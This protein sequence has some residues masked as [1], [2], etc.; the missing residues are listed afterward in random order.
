M[1]IRIP[2]EIECLEP[3]T[4]SDIDP[5]HSNIGIATIN[6]LVADLRRHE[7]HLG[8]DRLK[9][10]GSTDNSI[11]L[12]GK[13][14]N[15]LVDALYEIRIILLILIYTENEERKW[16]DPDGSD[17]SGASTIPDISEDHWEWEL[18]IEGIRLV[19]QELLCTCLNLEP[20]LGEELWM[21]LSPSGAEREGFTRQ[22]F[23][24][25][26]EFDEGD[27]PPEQDDLDAESQGEAWDNFQFAPSLCDTETLP[28]NPPWPHFTRLE[29]WKDPQI[30][31]CERSIC[32]GSAHPNRCYKFKYELAGSEGVRYKWTLEAESIED[33]DGIGSGNEPL[34]GDIVEHVHAIWIRPRATIFQQFGGDNIDFPGIDI[35][36]K[37]NGVE[38]WSGTLSDSDLGPD[39][40]AADPTGH[41][42]DP[43]D[44]DPDS[45]NLHG[46]EEVEI[47][48]DPI[49]SVQPGEMNIEGEEEFGRKRFG[50]YYGLVTSG[51]PDNLKGFHGLVTIKIIRP[52]PI[53]EDI[54]GF[55]V[56][57]GEPVLIEP[58]LEAPGVPPI[59]WSLAVFEYDIEEIVITDFIFDTETGILSFTP[60]G[61]GR[62]KIVFRATGANDKFDIEE[63]IIGVI[64]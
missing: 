8:A 16:C 41:G 30:S 58:E 35:T 59:E 56:I 25:E 39:L 43:D 3:E 20:P 10:A 1:P 11:Q 21:I 55:P 7:D 47:I 2:E 36:I 5:Y 38:I 49:T 33:V 19:L 17:Y 14:K 48:I 32:L 52:V 40:F 28:N 4:F 9:I 64:S 37:L 13:T 27:F 6:E 29:A 24:D 54:A 42:Q 60:I 12:V 34:V 53:I 57:S 18:I 26:V 50:M 51:V 46:F 22:G 15:I 61:E 44:I 45:L 63:V 62:I 23:P 31:N